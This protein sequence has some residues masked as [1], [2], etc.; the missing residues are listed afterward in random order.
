MC[1]NNTSAINW[2][3]KADRLQNWNVV[4]ILGFHGELAENCALLGYYAASSGNFLSTFRD[5]QSVSYSGILR[6]LNPDDAV[7]NYQHTLRNNP[8]DFSSHTGILS[9]DRAVTRLVTWKSVQLFICLSCV[10][11]EIVWGF[12]SSAFIASSLRWP[13]LALK[14]GWCNEREI[15]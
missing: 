4:W 11:V 13:T 6:F 9:S 15:R 12:L 10:E 14:E 5:N 2:A 1:H 7:R 3:R 8:R